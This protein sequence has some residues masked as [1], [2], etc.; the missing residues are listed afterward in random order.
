MR[1]CILCNTILIAIQYLKDDTGKSKQVSV[2]LDLV[3][4]IVFGRSHDEYWDRAI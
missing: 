3:K 2:A 4:A 1:V